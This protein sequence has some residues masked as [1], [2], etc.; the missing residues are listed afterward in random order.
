M[1]VTERCRSS[2]LRKEPELHLPHNLMSY[3]PGANIKSCEALH[4][5]GGKFNSK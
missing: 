1:L 4:R 2:T 5:Q 3:S